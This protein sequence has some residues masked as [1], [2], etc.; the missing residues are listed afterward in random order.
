MVQYNMNKIKTDIKSIPESWI[1]KFYAEKYGRA[2]NQ[3]FDGR[4]IKIRSFI[5][6]DS[7]P[8]LC[9]YYSP[10]NNKYLWYDHSSSRGGDVI[11]FVSDLLSKSYSITLDN[12]IDNFE[13]FIEEGKNLDEYDNVDPIE[14]KVVT[15]S[16][17]LRKYK[18][19]DIKYWEKFKINTNILIDYNVYPIDNYSIFKDNINVGTFSNHLCFGYYSNNIGL[20][21]IY[22]PE[23]KVKYLNVNTD[24]LIGSEQLKYEHDVCIITSGLKDLMA[25]MAVGLKV[26]SVAP[27]S[28]NTYIKHTD[29]DYLKSKYKYLITMFDNDDPGLK[30]MKNYKKIYGL[31]YIH[32]LL[33]QDL[34]KN[35]EKNNLMFLREHYS[36]YINKI[37]NDNE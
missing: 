21:Q 26:E 13:K 37:I 34:A 28:E 20:Y 11:D 36:Y 24:Y 27:R 4:T 7:D 18:D 32:L 12:I 22:Q 29:I 30:A 31:P 15:Y 10:K 8:S 3:P 17:T 9:I 14:Q 35:N 6:R 16:A 2:I 1:Y 23:N 33:E 19:E 5:H 25:L